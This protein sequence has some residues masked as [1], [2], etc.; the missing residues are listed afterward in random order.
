[1]V[2]RKWLFYFSSAQTLR[3]N[4]SNN[5]FDFYLKKQKQG[6]RGI[7]SWIDQIRRNDKIEKRL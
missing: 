7:K 2:F 1:M 5:V 3:S 6:S 4:F